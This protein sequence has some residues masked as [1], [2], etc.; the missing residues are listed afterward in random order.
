MPFF[1]ALRG[2]FWCLTDSVEV[3]NSLSLSGI[4]TESCQA[5]VSA[6]SL[7][8]PPDHRAGRHLWNIW[9]LHLPLSCL[10]K[11]EFLHN[12]IYGMTTEAV[13]GSVQ[14]KKHNLVHVPEAVDQCILQKHLM[15]ADDKV[16]MPQAVVPHAFRSPIVAR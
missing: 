7:P 12:P 1:V 13:M 15:S 16:G 11:E 9:K 14:N 8:F 10:C 3:P 6:Q 5:S 4:A 2:L